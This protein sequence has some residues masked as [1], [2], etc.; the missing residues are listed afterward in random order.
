MCHTL[1]AFNKLI[2][3]EVFLV[4][5]NDVICQL[6]HTP[7]NMYQAIPTFHIASGEKLGDKAN[8]HTYF[9]MATCMLV[10]GEDSLPAN[11]PINTL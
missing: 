1:Q 8:R 3:Q 7:E 6:R 10:E 2:E 5:K 9:T 4:L 11:Y